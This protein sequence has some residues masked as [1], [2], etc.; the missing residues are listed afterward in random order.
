VINKRPFFDLPAAGVCISI[1]AIAWGVHPASATDA[2]VT[3]LLR[4]GRD[5]YSKGD[6][7]AAERSARQ[8]DVAAKGSLAKDDVNRVYIDLLLGQILVARGDYPGAKAS[9]ESGLAWL[10]A[11]DAYGADHPALVG[12]L[13]NLADL[14]ILTGDFARAEKVAR[15]AVEVNARHPDVGPTHWQ[16][17]KAMHN[18][19]SVYTE[20]GDFTAA[21]E[22]LKK[23]IDIKRDT[24]QE[25]ADPLA[26]VVSL[27]ELAG[28]Y[29][30]S[31]AY[32]KAE[33]LHPQILASRERHSGPDHP[34]TARVINNAAR[35]YRAM[36][37][38]EKAEPLQRRAGDIFERVFPAEH[39]RVAHA[40]SNLG[41]LLLSVGKHAEARKLFEKSAAVRDKVLGPANPLTSISW[42]NLA[43][44]A[45]AG[46]DWAAA[47]DAA[48]RGRRG[49]RRHVARVLP[50]LTDREQA[51]FLKVRDEANLHG[52]LSLGL[53]RG[54][55][56]AAAERSAGWLSNAKAV[57]QEAAAERMKIDTRAADPQSRKSAE[58]LVAADRIAELEEREQRAILELGL[59]LDWIDREDPWVAIGAIRA[60]LPAGSVFIDIARFRPRDFAV[61]A[62]E[63][64]RFEPYGNP[65]YV[66]WIVPP[67]GRDRVRVVDLGEAAAIDALVAEYR[68]RIDAAKGAEGTIRKE[69]EAAA[70]AELAVVAAPLAKRTIEPLLAA[71]KEAIGKDPQELVISPDGP[72]WLVP[73]A[74]LVLADGRYAVEAV[75]IRHVTSG[76]DLV[77]KKAVSG[78]GA[79][80]GV[81]K[82]LIMAAPNFDSQSPGKSAARPA[83]DRSLAQP[84]RPSRRLPRAEP[85]PGTLEEA[86]GVAD[87]VKRIAA[88]EPEIVVADEATETR[89]KATPRPA[90]AIL[91]T[92][93]F[94]LGDQRLDPDA[95]AIQRDGGSRSLVDA[96]GD[97][98][99]NPLTR[100]GLML[101][102]CNRES[103]DGE[104]G[105]LTG[106]EIVGCDLRGTRLVML[107]ACQTG[108]GEVEAGQ[109]VA[110]LRQ[111]F[112]LAGAQT[113]VS[114]LWSVP[115]RET[116]ELSNAMFAALA[117][118]VQ[119]AEAVR[120]AQLQL[121]RSR[122]DLLEAAHP[123][124]W[125]AFT[126]TGN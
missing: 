76:R 109:G 84:I 88:A 79:S 54:A 118:G 46:G 119:P 114:T 71:A 6:Y 37:R 61:S 56:P 104:D 43:F 59:A 80:R 11:A 8:A 42:Q 60:A 96:A 85:L 100:C 44:A 98:I 125:A 48:D 102:G 108:L 89:F 63:G 12:P 112:Q 105:V 47:I 49:V 117:E 68:E 22:L 83:G 36:G 77:A 5:R 67:A 126:V 87:A 10:E 1:V 24:K 21:E 75:A 82:P 62:R 81:R 40:A 107:S 101:A 123:F 58:E 20:K 124:Y 53:Q 9:F 64:Q 113:V 2:E 34:E 95:L 16:T 25:T 13:S 99:E 57:G 116:A 41:E 111:A 29:F 91:A 19:A 115:D 72:L 69:G 3:R 90:L 26:V 27:E 110:G 18:L 28:V 121:I 55:D 92:H 38:Y 94:F 93:G 33:P 30:K 52:V 65:R 103:S 78:D 74:A 45:A 23:V 106:L 50:A 122:R 31:G 35:L 32:A 86:R 70:Q 51:Q 120:R 4:D 39:P 73:F 97:E 7:V 66:A 14:F 15:R 17:A